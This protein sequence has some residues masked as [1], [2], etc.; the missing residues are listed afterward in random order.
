MMIEGSAALAVA[1]FLKS[2]ERFRNRTVALV[3][4]GAKLGLDD[5]RE[6]LRD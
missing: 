4:S 1:A 2:K 5:L 3:L 6:I